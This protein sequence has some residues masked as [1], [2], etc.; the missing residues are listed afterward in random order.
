M[1]S[2]TVLDPAAAPLLVEVAAGPGG[3]PLLQ[4]HTCADKGGLSL[5]SG[6]AAPLQ[7]AARCVFY[8]D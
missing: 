8:G 6:F 5:R 4:R 7:K 3:G 2:L 1:R